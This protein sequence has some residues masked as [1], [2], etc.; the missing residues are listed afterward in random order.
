MMMQ[1][2][3]LEKWKHE[4]RMT[5]DHYEKVITNIKTENAYMHDV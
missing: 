5:V 2:K 3:I 1:E 4:H